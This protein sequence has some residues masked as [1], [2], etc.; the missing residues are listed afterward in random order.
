MWTGVCQ[1]WGAHVGRS[2]TE[3]GSVI[4][5]PEF[6]PLLCLGEAPGCRLPVPQGETDRQ[7]LLEGVKGWERG[8]GSAQR[9][10]AWPT[11]ACSSSLSPWGQLLPPA[12]WR[13]NF[14]TLV[15]RC[16]HSQVKAPGTRLGPAPPAWGPGGTR[17]TCL[18]PLRDELFPLL[19][20][21]FPLQP[22]LC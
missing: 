11:P 3:V 19:C 4:S 2:G 18:S 17:I 12:P 9:P 7:T 1:F 16:H 21:V 6:T 15:T 14:P 5:T 8:A 13:L 10:T 22:A 20:S